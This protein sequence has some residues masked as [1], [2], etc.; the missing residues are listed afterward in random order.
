M[1]YDI[2]PQKGVVKILILKHYWLKEWDDMMKCQLE[3][4]LRRYHHRSL[5]LSL[6]SLHLSLLSFI[7][8]TILFILLTSLFLF[9]T[10]CPSP[11]FLFQK[12][13]T[14]FDFYS[15]ANAERRKS[16][17]GLADLR[18]GTIPLVESEEE[19]V[20]DKDF[21]SHKY[22]LFKNPSGK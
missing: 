11:S 2:T 7:H 3:V 14:F 1:P 6:S 15:G 8:S 16:L 20:L 22:L 18:T 9:D 21:N 10:L 4:C 17:Q 19:S 5:S 12:Q 13:L